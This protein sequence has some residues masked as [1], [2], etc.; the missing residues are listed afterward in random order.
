M[1]DAGVRPG[2]DEQVGKIGQ[3]GAEVGPR[4]LRPDLL[5]TGAVFARYR[6]GNHPVGGVVAG[7]PDDQVQV[8]VLAI[9]GNDAGFVD[10][11]DALL[12]AVQRH[13]AAGQGRVQRAGQNHPFAADGVVRR[14]FAPQF[15]VRHLAF[16]EV[17]GL[18]LN[19]VHG[20]LR[21]LE[22][23]HPGFELPVDP[24]AQQLVG[25]L[26]PQQP[27][28]EA[29]KPAISPGQHPVGRALEHMQVPDVRGNGRNDLGRTGAAADDGHAF[30][31]IVVAVIPVV[32]M[33]RLALKAFLSVEVWNHRLTQRPGRVDQELRA[34]RSFAGGVYRPALVGVVPFD[35]LD[36]GVQ[37]HFV[38]QAEVFHHMA[39]VAVQFGLFGE[40]LRPAIRGERQGV[41][42]RGH[43]DCRAGVGVLAPGAAEEIPPLQQAKIVD[44]GLEQINC[45]TLAAKP[46][47]DDQYLKGLH[48]P[49]L[50]VIDQP[51]F[52]V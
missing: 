17:Q 5:E 13:V 14:Q 36:I 31:P 50:M 34:K 12:A 15:G 24:P 29:A 32:G 26:E 39:G 10:G 38:P 44:A 16:E 22:A 51:F 6:V 19:H 48:G 45:G 37:F 8:N 18:A 33:K 46:A 52:H 1:A 7:G 49:P 25:R 42:R 27:A 21:I 43:V 2:D 23:K 3:G 47:A 30:L 9:P 35:T 4:V 28:L 20:R 11:R 40:H 41:K